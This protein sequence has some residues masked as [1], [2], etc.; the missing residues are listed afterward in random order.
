M[1][2]I[3]LFNSFVNHL[4]NIFNN[5]SLFLHEIESNIN[6]STNLLNL[7]TI[8]NI[9]EFLDLKFKNSKE[10]NAMYYVQQ[11]RQRTL[12]TS[13]GIVNFNKTYYKSKKKID[14]KYQY[15]S[16]LEDYLGISKWAKL[17]LKAEVNLI[18][19]AID[20]GMTWASKNTIPNYQVS[21]QTISVKIKNINYN[22][23]ENISKAVTPKIIYIEADEVHANLQSKHYNKKKLNNKIIPVILTHEGHK[24]EFTKQKKLKNAHYIASS[25]LKT[26]LLWNETYKY[27]DQK[28]DLDK[29]E[30]FF[31]SGDGAPW[32]KGYDEAFPNA[33]YVLDPFHYQKALTY[34]FKNDVEMKI[35]ADICLREDRIDEFNLAIKT[36]IN[37]HPEQKTYILQKKKYL[38]NN[39]QG[40]KNQKHPMYKCPCSMEGHISNKY[41]RFLTSRP[42]AY[43]QDGLE[44]NT[45][46]LTLKANNITLTEEM[47]HQFKVGDAS[48]KLLNLEKFITNFRLQANKY[49]NNNINTF[50]TCHSI[51]NSSFSLQDNYRLDYYL[52]KRI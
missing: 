33:I 17:S 26:N 48:Y 21:R 49:T 18:N 12:I 46:L 3:S 34:I 13:L 23:V 22:Y 10:R 35:Y 7:D 11:T 6:N 38:L 29:V 19:N 25:L 2:I 39:I 36:A 41:A 31:I 42:H 51:D 47:Y 32:I 44:N 20:N 9:L 50:H 43:S 52:S 8:K 15:Y 45:Q 28:Y 24:E 37:L 4:N 16:Y 14:G 27:L 1:D 40:I 30:Y 5:N